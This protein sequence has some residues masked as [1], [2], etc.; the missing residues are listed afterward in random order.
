M[1]RLSPE[2]YLPAGLCNAGVLRRSRRLSYLKTELTQVCSLPGNSARR[3]IQ[4][5]GAQEGSGQHPGSLCREG[6]PGSCGHT[7]AQVPARGPEA[8]LGRT[9]TD[10]R[11]RGRS[12]R[13]AQ[14]STTGPR[15]APAQPGREPGTGVQRHRRTST[16]LLTA[17]SWVQRGRRRAGDSRRGLGGLV[18]P[19]GTS[20]SSPR[21]L[22]SLILWEMRDEDA[23]A[24]SPPASGF[25]A[26]SCGRGS[27]GVAP[28]CCAGSAWG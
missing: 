18:P 25:P 5:P 16:F 19:M 14:P 20:P 12:Q 27:L 1:S 3:Q 13:A 23:D 24:A 28:S 7:G 22:L 26:Q 10:P 9:Q 17:D 6:F 11:S 15:A 4:P 2:I 8:A 21:V